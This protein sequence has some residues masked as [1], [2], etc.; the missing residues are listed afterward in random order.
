MSHKI[1][2]DLVIWCPQPDQ[3]DATGSSRAKLLCSQRGSLA[4]RSWLAILPSPAPQLFAGVFGKGNL[5]DGSLAAS[6]TCGTIFAKQRLTS[7]NWRIGVIFMLLRGFSSGYDSDLRRSDLGRTS[8]GIT[9]GATHGPS[10]RIFSSNGCHQPPSIT[11]PGKFEA[12]DSSFLRFSLM[13][14]RSGRENRNPCQPPATQIRHLSIVVTLAYEPNGSS[15]LSWASG[16]PHSLPALGLE[17][18]ASPLSCVQLGHPVQLPST[19]PS[20][21]IASCPGDRTIR[22]L[23]IPYLHTAS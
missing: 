15:A 11:S 22:R 16:R 6:V 14:G 9:H 23:S 17:Q 5:C 10:L 21:D 1:E 4:P 18:F 13:T 3:L 19:K 8:G 7:E 2:P 12:R 20:C